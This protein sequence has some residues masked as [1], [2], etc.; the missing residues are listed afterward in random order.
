MPPRPTTATAYSRRSGSA[1]WA[2]FVE[3]D[4]SAQVDR[5]VGPRASRQ[6]RATPLA[7]LQGPPE[8]GSDD[9]G[10]CPGRLIL[11]NRHLGRK[12]S[13]PDRAGCAILPGPRV[14]RGL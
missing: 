7:D 4:P 2:D 11:G 5:A 9:H 3:D 8:A 13:A 14:P 12:V 10:R 6:A 1:I